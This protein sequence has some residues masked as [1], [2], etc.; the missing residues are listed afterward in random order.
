[1]LPRRRS[2]VI[3]VPW[4][5][6]CTIA[7]NDNISLKRRASAESSF[8]QRTNELAGSGVAEFLRSQCPGAKQVEV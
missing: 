6:K 3:A 4:L 7:A 8:A 5:T 1:M 2:L